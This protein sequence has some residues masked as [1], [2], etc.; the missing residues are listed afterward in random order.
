MLHAA[1]AQFQNLVVTSLLYTSPVRHKASSILMIKTSVAT[2][3]N[4]FAK[5]TWRWDLCALAWAALLA[6]YDTTVAALW[7]CAVCSSWV[8]VAQALR[9]APRGSG[10][11]PDHLQSPTAATC[12]LC[13]FT[14]LYLFLHRVSTRDSASHIWRHVALVSPWVAQMWPYMWDLK[15]CFLCTLDPLVAPK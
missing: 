1:G 6:L 9:A 8:G 14:A 13:P 12:H 7:I 2:V 10:S 11:P 4:L 5:S 15:W 3:H